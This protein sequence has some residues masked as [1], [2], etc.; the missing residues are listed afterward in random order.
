MKRF[1]VST[2][3]F[4]SHPHL[5]EL[6]V[7]DHTK[8]DRTAFGFANARRLA[9]ARRTGRTGEGATR[10]WAPRSPLS[11]TRA[12][13]V[14]ALGTALGGRQVAGVE[15]GAAPAH[16][17]PGVWCEHLAVGI[18]QA[19]QLPPYSHLAALGSLASCL[20]AARTILSCY[21]GQDMGFSEAP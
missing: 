3:F 16:L 8:V 13:A 9:P 21:S 2:H 18:A 12:H 20:A 6:H 11:R 14:R 10:R 15:Q 5:W 7:P 19:P 1:G 17:L 4:C